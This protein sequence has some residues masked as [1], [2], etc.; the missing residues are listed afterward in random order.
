MYVD[1]N[2]DPKKYVPFRIMC[3]KKDVKLTKIT[4]FYLTIQLLGWACRLCLAFLLTCTKKQHVNLS[5]QP[6]SAWE[7]VYQVV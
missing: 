6:I 4:L 1:G 3:D 2:I 5:L 7:V